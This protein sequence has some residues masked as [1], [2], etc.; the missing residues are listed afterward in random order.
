[1]WINID[2]LKTNATITNINYHATIIINHVY[3]SNQNMD[4]QILIP[5]PQ[6]A[7][8]LH[9]PEPN[10]RLLPGTEQNNSNFA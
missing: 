4:T 1:M 5:R 10:E 3:R 6:I 8:T 2:K 9:Q 7:K